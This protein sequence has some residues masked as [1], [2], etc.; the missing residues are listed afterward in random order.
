MTRVAR[1]PKDST[2]KVSNT[3]E[4]TMTTD[5]H[6]GSAKIYQFP[7]RPRTALGGSRPGENPVA[8]SLTPR[9]AAACGS[10]WYHEAALQDAGLPSKN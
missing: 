6:L 9:V 10:A 3:K 5:Y 4:R 8:A 1:G 2:Q 7:A